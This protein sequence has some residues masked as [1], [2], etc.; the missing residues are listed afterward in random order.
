MNHSAIRL[1]EVEDYASILNVY[2]HSKLDELVNESASFTLLPLD[3]DTKRLAELQES[4]IYVYEDNGIVAYGAVFESEIRALF[5]HSH[6]RGKGIG[7]TLFRFLLSKLS[8]CPI[9]QTVTLH[10]AKS[11]DAAK[12]LYKNFGF[13]VVEEFMAEYNGVD[14]MANKMQRTL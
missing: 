7:K 9:N 14:V 13:K 11:N 12:A 5:V 4:D 6:S 3:R 10:V 2:A 8:P 1:F